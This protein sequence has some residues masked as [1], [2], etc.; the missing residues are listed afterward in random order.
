[1]S[2]STRV[3]FTLDMTQEEG[4]FPTGPFT[5]WSSGDGQRAV[6]RKQDPNALSASGYRLVAGY[7]GESAYQ[8]AV[9]EAGD[10]NAV[11]QRRQAL[12]KES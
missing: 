6:V 3:S 7:S 1:M 12:R 5:A 10:L 4:V 11:E 8:D 9:R 2:K